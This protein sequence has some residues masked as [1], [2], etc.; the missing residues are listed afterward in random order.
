L[1]EVFLYAHPGVLHDITV[2]SNSELGLGLPNPAGAGCDMATG[3]GSPD[4]AALAAA[5]IAATTLPSADPTVLASTASS[6]T[7]TPGTPVTLSGSLTDSTTPTRMVSGR[8]VT[9][10][11]TYTVAGQSHTVTKT[12]TTDSGGNW[13]VAVTTAE[14][15]AR[16]TWQ[17]AF[18]G[19]S[20][21]HASQSSS[22][23]LTVQPTLTTS[24]N[25]YWNGK[26]YSAVH[27]TVAILS[28]VSTPAMAGAVLTVQTKPSGTTTWVSSAITATVA[29]DG[30]YSTSMTFGKAVKE[31]IRF[32]Y[33]GKQS[34]PWL[35]AKSP[36]RV[37][38]IT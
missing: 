14:V 13:N 15:G 5:L 11:G 28:G 17:A 24:A 35:S 25:L 21:F 3:Q 7:I 19:D 20:A 29:A 23:V 34:G 4:G 31:S 27:G 12:A 36:A 30:T 32:T 8:T 9:I 38:S 1:V 18:A 26:Q 16:F 6:T 37:F 33:A 22:H 10:T 2:G